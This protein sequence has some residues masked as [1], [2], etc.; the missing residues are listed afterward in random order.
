M[1]VHPD[2]DNQQE[3]FILCSGKTDTVRFNGTIKNEPMEWESSRRE[4]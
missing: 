2:Q 4:R 3:I 1:S